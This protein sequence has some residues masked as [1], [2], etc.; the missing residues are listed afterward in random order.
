MEA[1]CRTKSVS[2]AANELGLGQPAVSVALAK[3]R[4]YFGDAL[5]VRTT[6]GMVPTTE[7]ARL[8][9]ISKHLLAAMAE[10][11]PQS[12]SFDPAQTSRRFR[13]GLNQVT[14]TLLL[15]YLSSRMLQE[16]PNCTIDTIAISP[17]SLRGLDTGATDLVIGKISTLHEGYVSLTVRRSEF[18]CV[19]SAKHPRVRSQ[20][21][22]EQ[23]MAERHVVIE[24]LGSIMAPA[25][26]W[27]AKRKLRRDVAVRVP[28][29][30]GV[31]YIVANTALVATVPKSIAQYFARN[32]KVQVLDHPFDLPQSVSKIYWHER[33]QRDAGHIWLRSVVADVIR[34]HGEPRALAP[35][36]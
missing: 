25:E 18:A 6:A 17:E 31:D 16:A 20:I 34:A 15:P 14:Q 22:S 10:A 36:T 33:S 21:T 27:M 3:L 13:I 23:F 28:D 2:K 11:R 5:F 30:L 9:E 32:Q 8:L 26:E 19:A 12:A 4:S 24:G 29:F 35:R 1:V 7:G